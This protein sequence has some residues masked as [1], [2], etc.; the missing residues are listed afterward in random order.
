MNRRKRATHD[1]TWGG[2]LTGESLMPG[3]SL[4]LVVLSAAD[5][6]MTYVLLWRGQFYEANPIALWFFNRWNVA[7][8]TSFKFGMVALIVTLSETIERH[9]PGVGRAIL[10]FGSVAAVLVTVHGFRLLMNHG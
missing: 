9:R 10:L 8:L 5:L 3:E 1:H 4:L 7:G 6:F 2:F